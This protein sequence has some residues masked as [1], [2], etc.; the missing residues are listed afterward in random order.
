MFGQPAAGGMH[1]Q[2]GGMW[3]PP[4][5]SQAAPPAPAP[6]APV[7]PS[8]MMHS[9]PMAAQIGQIS[10]FVSNPMF[11]TMAANVT[12]WDNKKQQVI[13]GVRHMCSVT[14]AH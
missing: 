11:S 10:N 12:D 4:A 5:P 13:Y 3:G 2:A 9:D 6:Q 7:Q 14:S 8:P 1:N